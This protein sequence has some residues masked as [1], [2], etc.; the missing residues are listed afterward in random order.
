MKDLE[1][2]AL[3][4]LNEMV[5]RLG[6]EAEISPVVSD[7]NHLK[8]HIDSEEAGRLIGRKGQSLESLELLLNRILKCNDENNPWVPVEVDG[9]ST[10]RTGG[11]GPRRRGLKV[12]EE[13][14]EAMANDTA[15]EVRLWQ[16][17]KKI[18]P[19]LPAER[20][21]IH[22]TLK[23]EEDIVTE[24]EEI[25]GEKAKKYIIVKFIEE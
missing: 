23:N 20:R 12:D 9:Y 21:I 8:L 13:K 3:T 18:G 2:Q 14:L 19:F 7:E 15:K 24:S 25:E 16:K 4:T 11:S 10:G 6:I 22:L 17:D 5:G 1:T